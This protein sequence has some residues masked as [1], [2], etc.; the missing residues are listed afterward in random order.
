MAFCPRC[1]VQLDNDVRFCPLDGTP[2]PVLE[3]DETQTLAPWPNTD[4]LAK[5]YLTSKE[6]RDRLLIIISGLLILPIFV[7]LAVDF[8]SSGGFDG[9]TLT[10]SLPV[11][12]ILLC[13]FLYLFFGFNLYHAFVPVSLSYL[14]IT[15][16]LLLGLDFFNEQ[17]DWFLTLGLPI[18]SALG[19]FLLLNYLFILKTKRKG[20]N[21]FGSIVASIAL[22]L[23]SLDGLIH[24]YL[25]E[26]FLV[27]WS[28]LT[29]FALVPLSI[30][31]FFLH[32]GLKR[33][34][35]LGRTFHF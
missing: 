3:G 9:G 31:F 30:Y 12:W 26:R 10:W 19:I 21:V 4:P 27:S 28:I 11:A 24:Y 16:G 1:G 18:L 6:I 15:A 5:K 33:N 32:Y 14:G 13:S 23:I 22:F 35:D 29:S 34:L 8:Y 7:V 25:Q 17:I 20:Y 2:I